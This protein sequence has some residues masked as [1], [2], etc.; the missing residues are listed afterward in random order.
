M[1]TT[2]IIIGTVSILVGAF[3]SYVFYKIKSIQDK[4]IELENSFPTPE[5]VA[6]EVLKVKMPMSQLPPEFLQNLKDKTKELK[7]YVG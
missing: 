6:Q 1:D 5:E 2:N 4:L 7:S 3:I